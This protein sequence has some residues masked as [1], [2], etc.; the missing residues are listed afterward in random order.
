MS[1]IAFLLLAFLVLPAAEASSCEELNKATADIG[2]HRPYISSVIGKGRLYFHSAPAEEC[3]EKELF[4]IPGDRVAMYSTYGPYSQILYKDYVT[5]V[6]TEWLRVIAKP[7]E[8]F[9]P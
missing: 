7:D 4:V 3:E 9:V 2:S 6:L 1:R 8:P 5:W